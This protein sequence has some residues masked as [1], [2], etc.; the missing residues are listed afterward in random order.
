[1]ESP[2]KHKSIGVLPKAKRTKTVNQRF[3]KEYTEKYPVITASRIGER[4][5]FCTVCRLDISVAHGGIH[6]CTK[7]VGSVSHRQKATIASKSNKITSFMCQ[8]DQYDSINAEA[9]F[10]NFVTEHNLPISV[11]D[12][13]GPL[14]RKMFPDSDI[15]KK[16]MYACSRTKKTAI[17]EML[18]EEDDGAMTKELRSR[19]YSLATGW[20]QI[21]IVVS[22]CKGEGACCNVMGHF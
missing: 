9:M 4:H 8:G 6:D 17:I 12:H 10:T 19:P 20:L 18:G 15:S 7:H 13:A 2:Q 3:K 11:T 21:L 16:Y 22:F 14:F 1:M 5:A